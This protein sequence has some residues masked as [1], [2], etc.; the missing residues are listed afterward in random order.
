MAGYAGRGVHGCT[1]DVLGGRIVSGEIGE[2]QTIDVAG[3][4]VELDVSLTAIR[5]ALR[6]LG[7]KGLVDARQRRGTFVRDRSRWQLL[8][9]D[10]IRWQFASAEAPGFLD[11]LHEIRGIV[12]PSSARLAAQRRTDAD[13][14]SL[15]YHLAAMEAATG[16]AAAAV[17]ADLDFHRALFAAT[18]NE[19]LHRMEV[20]IETG[21]AER[22]RLVHGADPHDDPTPSHRAVL[23]A[24]R[25]KDP[26]AAE[27]AVR[28]LLDKAVSDL[29]RVRRRARASKRPEDRS[30]TV[31]AVN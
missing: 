11:D 31:S 4:Q 5:E 13:V 28:T 23:D 16:D 21:L 15:T 1:V 19:L 8:D 12:E 9:A 29:E 27:L 25:S 24:I 26:D 10:V 7:A 3:L 22:D 20:V 6:V 17:R 14:E 30:T 18:H 2:G